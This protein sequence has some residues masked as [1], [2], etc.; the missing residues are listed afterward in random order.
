VT[1]W[2]FT[3]HRMSGFL[4]TLFGSKMAIA[5]LIILIVY[6]FLAVGANVITPY[7]PETSIVAGAYAPPSWYRYLSEGSALSQNVFLQQSP[8]FFSDPLQSG[9]SWSF[10]AS[11]PRVTASYDPSFSYVQGGGSVRVTLDRIAGPGNYTATFKTT[12]DW[13]YPGPPARLIASLAVNAPAGSPELPVSATLFVERISGGYA[14]W[15]LTDPTSTIVRPAFG[16][17]LSKDP[18]I[19]YYRTGTNATWVPG[20]PVI[21]DSNGNGKYDTGETAIV[22]SLPQKGATLSTDPNLKYIDTSKSGNW[23]A[24]DSVVYDSNGSGFF[25]AADT[26]VAG[27]STGNNNLSW[28]SYPFTTPGWQS[29]RS[30]DSNSGTLQQVVQ[31]RGLNP[32]QLIFGSKDQYTFGVRVTINSALSSATPVNVYLDNMNL[33]IYGT[34]FG[35]LGTDYQ[36]ADVWSQLIYGARI[37]LMVGLLSAFIGILLGLVVGLVAG[38]L[39]KVV[40]EVLMRFTD[41]LL[42]IPGLPLLI[43]LVTVL[44]GAFGSGRTLALILVIGFLGWMGFAR[45]VRSQVLSLKERP[46]VEAAKAAGAGSG[47]IT[48]R[49]ILPNIVGLIYVNLALAV[50]GAILAE[51][52][53]SFLGLGDVSVLSWGRMLNLVET[54]GSQ[55]IWWWVIPP[56]LSI[57][58]VSV[59]F[60]MIGF[61]LDTLFNPRL[62]QR[63]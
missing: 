41:M 28:S 2:R 11:D 19:T 56:G 43:V 42:V 29:P 33:K 45:V 51:A 57:A 40:D 5:G 47:H 9:T 15:N 62:R 12:F 38:Y 10:A 58:L 20:E 34:S 3:L 16:S 36:G 54:T 63:I 4:R 1:D 48:I 61:S 23:T 55:K 60:V 59:A 53:L 35:L 26:L 25:D 39:G 14:K 18:L 8:G 52:A 27:Q 31:K 24:V 44:G 6:T 46:F 7:D 37:S 21:Y 17:L 22:G 32:A 49:H 13:P 50:P 30:L